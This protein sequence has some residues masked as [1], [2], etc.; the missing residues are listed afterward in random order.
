MTQRPL[1]LSRLELVSTVNAA[2]EYI[3][4]YHQIKSPDEESQ[5]LLAS[6]HFTLA[7]QTDM[8]WSQCKMH[9][10]AAIT[11][12][13]NLKNKDAALTTM[14]ANAYFRRA[15]Y[16]ECESSLAAAEQDYHRAILA[17]EEAA[18]T[19]PLADQ[20]LLVLAQCAISIADLSLQKMQKMETEAQG[21]KTLQDTQP[22]Y[23]SHPLYYVNKSL[24]YLKQVPKTHQEI[25][26][27]LAYAHHIAGLTLS[28]IDFKEAKE[29]FRTAI[30]MAFKAEPI[31][32]CDVLGDIYNSL[33]LLYEQ[34]FHDCIIEKHSKKPNDYALLYFA[35]SLFFKVEHN[36]VPA[37]KN[38]LD[39]IF[40]TIYRALDPFLNPLSPAVLRDFIDALIFVYYCVSDDI[41][42]NQELCQQLQETNTFNNFAQ[43]IFWLVAESYRRQDHNHRL[44]EMIEL[45]ESDLSLDLQG[46]LKSLLAGDNKVIYLNAFEV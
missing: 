19:N 25:W 43:H 6:A 1:P 42:P 45:H 5:S 22:L 29:A 28:S 26:T 44:L 9:T 35:V 10:N 4:L 3:T 39:Q 30:N 46:S 15:G 31:E 40:E 16:F 20:D 38:L 13:Q 41:L 36:H 8:H 2:K 17:F 11:L 23:V 32:A 24:E 14:I 33:G 27:N 12:L 34:Q 18:K 21:E 7:L 37:D